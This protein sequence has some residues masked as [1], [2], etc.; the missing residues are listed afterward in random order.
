[1]LAMS[2]SR[3]LCFFLQTLATLAA[4]GIRRSFQMQSKRI[5]ET[6]YTPHATVS[7][8]V[9]TDERYMGSV[10]G[11]RPPTRM[12]TEHSLFEDTALRQA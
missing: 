7:A 3:W 1:M 10:F 2:R 6:Y 9:V 5:V 8:Q 11:G 12:M 4:G